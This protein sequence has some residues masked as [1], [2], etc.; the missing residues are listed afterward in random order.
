MKLKI[1][2]NEIKDAIESARYENHYIIDK[3]KNKIIFISEIEADYTQ[4]L[5]E[6]EGKNFICIQP[7]LP[8]EDFDI[9]HS[10]LYELQDFNLSQELEKVLKKRKPFQ[11]F[12]IFL[13][14]HP[15]LQ[16]KWYKYKDNELKNKTM[17]WLFTNKIELEDKS[18]IPKIEIK[19]LKPNEV[20]LPEGF[21]GFGPVE[22]MNCKN[23]KDFKTRYFELNISNDNLLI[24]NEI[25]KIMEEKY[26]IKDYG[27][28]S[29]GEK[30]ILTVSECP[31]CKNTNIFQDF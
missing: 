12:K 9:M 2:F 1:P 17:N 8:Q 10:F 25:N 29:G 21:D 6:T 19:E 22:C 15:E 30:E 26:K 20:K 16:E 27:H 7:K 5:E 3:K 23:K 24:D 18:F 28:I 14:K 4:K 13:I 11:Q 31:N